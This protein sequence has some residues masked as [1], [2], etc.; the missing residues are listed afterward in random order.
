MLEK[1]ISAL[2]L[3]S[4]THTWLFQKHSL[5]H[6]STQ[7]L[8]STYSPFTHPCRG[9]NPVAP[10][11]PAH[12]RLPTSARPLH[13]HLSPLTLPMGRLLLLCW[14]PEACGPNRPGTAK[15]CFVSY[16]FFFLIHH[17]RS[18]VSTSSEAVEYLTRLVRTQHLNPFP[19]LLHQQLRTQRLPKRNWLMLGRNKAVIQIS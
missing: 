7:P 13:P 18:Q 1:A 16:I 19:G 12:R 8:S 4:L 3:W 6:E 11:G 2:K 9:T 10:V 17:D 5:R 14:K 15:H